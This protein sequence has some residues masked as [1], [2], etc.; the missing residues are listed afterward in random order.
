MTVI[1]RGNGLTISTDFGRTVIEGAVPGG[2]QGGGRVLTFSF[3]QSP[4]QY[5]TLYV[6]VVP[7]TGQTEDFW[8]DFWSNLINGEPADQFALSAFV[9]VEPRGTFSVRLNADTF[10]EPDERFEVR[11][12]QDN[13]DAAFG[14]N[15]LLSASF[16]V[17]DDDVHGTAGS[18]FLSGRAH[19]E[20]LRAYAGNDTIDGGAGMDTMAGGPGDDVYIVE[21][22]GDV[23][24]EHANAG[25]DTVMASASF[26]L[27]P[28]IENLTL[29]GT[30]HINGT[31]NDLKNL[32]NGNSGNNL[33]DGGPGSDTL[34]G[35]AG[36]DTYHVTSGDR[37]IELAGGGVDTVYSA[38]T[39]Q[40][41]ANV[42]H[43][44]LTGSA[45]VNA[46]GNDLG[47][48][49]TGN[50]GNNTLNGRG[51]AD[52]MAGAAG[53]D[54]YVVDN[55][56]DI[57]VEKADEGTDT[58]L[59][60][61]TWRLGAHVENL[62]L[63]GNAAIN[64][65]GNNMANR[66][67]GNAGNNLL[68]GGLGNDTLNGGASADRL[69]GDAGNDL[70]LGGLG[71]DTLN[72]GAGADALDGGIGNDVLVGGQGNDR[73]IGGA[74]AD[75]LI[76]G[77]GADVFVFTSAR[78][79]GSLPANRDI[80]ADF[81]RAQGDRIDLGAIDANTR[82]A[83]DQAF[84]FVGTDGFTSS[85]GELRIMRNAAG[86]HV[87]GDTDGDGR[88]DFSVLV[89]GVQGLIAADFLL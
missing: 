51:G 13:M 8:D 67:V 63:Q 64:G 40:L 61:V 73:L 81:S 20:Y 6:Q 87:L 85:A 29:T 15:P 24:I 33:L 65:T 68:S 11:V 62:T 37:V 60:S 45:N 82:I 34:Q 22:S 23:I 55:I 56:R 58:V 57:V 86:T 79:S 4:V 54:T 12:Y 2:D 66:I 77:L 48:R 5:R 26:R 35:G 71:N 25:T 47:N 14:R 75:R 10:Q 69:N 49:L 50:A 41:H 84:R 3:A 78:D 52:V 70:L 89:A 44:V 7:L 28:N 32:I 1:A 16:T 9:G 88:A 83:G 80:I 72:G 36:N 53:N 39:W 18:D 59:S 31:G 42:E 38:G 74:G 76:G 21:N 43:L 19:A 30:R 17:L 46:V 27:S